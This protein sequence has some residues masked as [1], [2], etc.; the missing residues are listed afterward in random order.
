MVGLFE[1]TCIV[2]KGG[3]LLLQ[4]H[5]IARVSVNYVA[6]ERT[7]EFRFALGGSSGLVACC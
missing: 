2:L 6:A 7:Q 5:E 3:K 4:V 1:G